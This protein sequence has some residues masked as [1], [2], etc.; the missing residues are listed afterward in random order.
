[1]AGTMAQKYFK[2][3]NFN[4]QLKKGKNE[5]KKIFQPKHFLQILLSTTTTDRR[6]LLLNK[7][8]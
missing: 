2:K 8:N 1:M 4:W 5:H 3:E 6:G 7:K